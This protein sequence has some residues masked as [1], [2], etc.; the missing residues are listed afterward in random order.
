VL[1]KLKKHSR[2]VVGKQ[3]Q[4]EDI[5]KELFTVLKELADKRKS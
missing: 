2:K 5:S 3:F 1:A 4:W